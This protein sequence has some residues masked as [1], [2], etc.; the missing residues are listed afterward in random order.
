MPAR[1]RPKTESPI[2]GL[3]GM[4]ITARAGAGMTDLE[5]RLRREFKDRS[6]READHAGQVENDRATSQSAKAQRM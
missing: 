3:Y 4:K 5:K 2:R 1:R 6:A